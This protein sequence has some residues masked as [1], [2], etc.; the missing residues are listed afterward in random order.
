M[1][2]FYEKTR[3]RWKGILAPLG[4]DISGNH[5]PCPI[6]AGT[7]RF[8]F[9]DRSGDGDYYCN[10]CGA[11]KGM[12]LYQQITG[13][14]WRDAAR[15]IDRII[16][17]IPETPAPERKDPRP[18]LR[19]IASGLIPVTE[20]ADVPAY[21]E[22]RNLPIA[23][24]LKAHP[25]IDYY[26]EGQKIGTYPAMVGKV[27]DVDANPVTLHVTYLKDGK[28][29][30]VP[31]P[32]K[33]MPVI[34]PYPGSAIRLFPYSDTLGIA[35]GIETALA[36]YQRDGIPTWSAICADGLARFNAPT[37]VKTLIIYGDH[38]ASYAGQKAAYTL[39]HREYQSRQVYV[40]I[41]PKPGDWADEQS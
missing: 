6:C 18:Y 7:D 25:G 29:A 22:S 38:D 41:P 24:G 26:H 23:P 31:K 35:E 21:L 16:G 12:Q 17:T 30:D 9:D 19:K 27:V 11:G 15:E 40:C 5:G 36:C 39:A 32:K 37:S 10:G 13:M 1:T 3:G 20:S 33:L 28:K 4:V 2:D 34:K 8:R 14:E